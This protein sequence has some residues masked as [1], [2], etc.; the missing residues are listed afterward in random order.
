[1]KELIALAKAKSGA[2]NVGASGNGTTNHL[3]GE[4]AAPA[5]TPA[6]VLNITSFVPTW[7]T[8]HDSNV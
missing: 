4:G 5:K 1:M 8:R 6:R 3:A 7:R 2:I